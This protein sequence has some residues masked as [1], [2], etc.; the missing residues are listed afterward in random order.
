MNIAQSMLMEFDHEMAQTRKTL[1]RVPDNLFGWRP[2]E[3]SFTMGELAS[4]IQ[5]I[6][7]WGVDV[8]IKDSYDVRP[9]D[10]EAH[11][12][13][14]PKTQADLVASFDTHRE[15]LRATLEKTSDESFMKPWSFSV[16]GKNVFTLPRVA[17]MR[18]M[19]MNHLIHHRGQLTMYFRLNNIP[20]P[21]LYGPSADEGMM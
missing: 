16:S 7:E 9:E 1:E 20:V 2:H 11:K 8:L 4:H 15:N 10:V 3:K 19:I 13:K 5:S 12:A 21:A 17:I 18:G 14:A 6:V